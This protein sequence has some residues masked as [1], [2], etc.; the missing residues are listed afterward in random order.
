M[1]TLASVF[2]IEP[3]RIGGQEAFGRELSIQLGRH[4]WDSL[5]CFLKEPPPQ[6][7][8]YLELP[9]VRIESVARMEEFHQ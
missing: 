5:L 4:G 1:P 3:F 8:R 9:N 6:V 7:R 2:A